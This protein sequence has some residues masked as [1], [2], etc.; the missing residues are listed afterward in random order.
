[1]RRDTYDEAHITYH[2]ELVVVATST[3]REVRPHA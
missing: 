3:L 2:S 1:M